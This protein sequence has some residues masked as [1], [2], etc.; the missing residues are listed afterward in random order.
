MGRRHLIGLEG[1]SNTPRCLTTLY[2]SICKK[3]LANVLRQN[4][5]WDMLSSNRP[6]QKSTLPTQYL[7]VFHHFPK[8]KNASES[9][10]YRFC[11]ITS[12]G[13]LDRTSLADNI[14][15][16]P[17]SPRTWIHFKTLVEI[18]H[19]QVA[20]YLSARREKYRVSNIPKPNMY[21]AQIVAGLDQKTLMLI[22]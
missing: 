19:R 3:I 13:T 9:C 10:L 22:R 4:G 5:C 17:L 15:S 20:L 12:C 7:A 6:N 21:R 8:G 2:A 11:M 18:Y 16:Q 1:F 14:I